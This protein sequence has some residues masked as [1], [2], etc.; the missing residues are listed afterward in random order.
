MSRW[1]TAAMVGAFAAVAGLAATAYATGLPSRLPIAAE[2]AQALPSAAPS[3]G[4]KPFIRVAGPQTAETG[5]GKNRVAQRTT[6]TACVTTSRQRD[7]EESLAQ[8]TA[9]GNITVDGR[10]S[11]AD[12]AIIRRFQQ[13]FGIEPARGQADATTADV[14]RRIAV[15]SQP[16]QLQRCD[17]PA[18]GVVA[19]V[20]LSLQ[21]AW[22]VRD[23]AV[24]L[25][26][27]V[28]RSGFRGYATPAGEYRVNKRALREWSDPY[29]VWLPYWQRFVGG[30]GF[31]ETTTYIH[32]KAIGSHGCINLL[33]R[34]A[35]DF[36]SQLSIDSPVRVFG[37]RPGT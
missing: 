29:R 35:A 4:L 32:D 12:C 15:S 1:A 36:W 18:E 5:A 17:P 23:G 14:A 31:H 37:Q 30:I 10:Q 9:Y 2:A 25:G 16:G 20:D 3:R 7:V 26:P 24:V 6:T 27:T 22:V 28:I 11:A 13:R 19:C 21:T 34:D 33:R 8:L